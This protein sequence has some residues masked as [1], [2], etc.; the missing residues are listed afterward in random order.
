[1]YLASATS[2]GIT[3]AVSKLS[4]FVAN[5]GDVHCHVVKRIMRYLKGTM[6]HRLHYTG[7]PSILEGYIDEN[8]IS[9]ADEI[10]CICLPLKVVL[11]P[12]SLVTKRS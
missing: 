5:R 10:K 12:R 11:F 3:F 9:H 4:R 8:W 1:M 7:Y 2:P 6:N